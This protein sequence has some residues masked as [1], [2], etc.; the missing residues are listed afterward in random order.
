MA[1]APRA[2]SVLRNVWFC[3]HTHTQIKPKQNLLHFIAM[4]TT[5]DV[6]KPFR[7]HKHPLGKH[8][9]ISKG[10]LLVKSVTL[11]ALKIVPLVEK[12]KSQ[13]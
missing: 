3:T 1:G 2:S 13:E 8:I 12:L 7:K 9:K 11:F 4:N 6:K 5:A 10:L